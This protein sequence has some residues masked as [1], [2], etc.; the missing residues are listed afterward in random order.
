M[1]LHLIYLRP[2]GLLVSKKP[3][4]G[5]REIQD[6]YDEYMTSLGPFTEDELL[7]FLAEEYGGDAAA[8]GFTREAL[9]A[10]AESSDAVLEARCAP[11]S[12]GE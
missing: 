6:E 8:W 3:Y 7:D 10:F 12:T 1:L 2:D 9:R 11:P 5:W 4:A